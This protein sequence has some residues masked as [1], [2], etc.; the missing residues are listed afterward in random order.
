MLLAVALEPFVAWM[1]RR[2]VS[3]ALSVSLLALLLL[4]LI[5]VGI[6]VVLP[7]LADQLG[8]LVTNF[9]AFRARVEHRLP[10]GN[11][12][13]RTVVDQIF[14]LPSSPEVLASVHEPLI[15]GR[16]A[17]SGV[18][19][20]F[21]VV[22]TTL[23]L[24]I[25]G[26]RLYAWLLAYVPRTHR[27][28]MAETVSGV[29]QVVY[30]YVRGQVVTSLLF[31]VFSAGVLALLSVRHRGIRPG[32]SVGRRLSDHRAPLARGLPRARGAGR[33]FGAREGSR[34]RQ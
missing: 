18:M 24:L 23:Y 3:R 2:N 8:D 10:Q 11:F 12:M 28:R 32:P 29:S 21:F 16:A 31:A 33:P 27:E 26:K 9:P 14:E 25:D 5:A 7:P 22:V 30:A 13:L 20:T 4:A 34:D 6:G 15:W 19:T 1:G 17:V